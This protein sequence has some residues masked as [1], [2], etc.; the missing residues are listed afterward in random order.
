MVIKFSLSKRFVACTLY[1]P[2]AGVY[3]CVMIIRDSPR[4][5]PQYKQ[6]EEE[7]VVQFTGTKSSYC[8][9]KELGET[10]TGSSQIFG[11]VT[12]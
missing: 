7:K 11:F 6:T 4:G 8:T 10:G 12:L 1:L 9:D 5:F 3:K 2:G